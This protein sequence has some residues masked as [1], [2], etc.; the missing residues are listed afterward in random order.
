MSNSNA[1]YQQ[2]S[3]EE[4]AKFYPRP[5]TPS[6]QPVFQNPNPISSNAFVVPDKPGS[7][8]INKFPDILQL[9]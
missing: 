9:V 2:P 8:I 4:E 1:T 6:M 5:S 7:K 3:N